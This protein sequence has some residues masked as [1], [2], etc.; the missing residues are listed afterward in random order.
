M[1]SKT[2]HYWD[3][4][5][6]V[7]GKYA[8]LKFTNIFSS[9]SG[10][11]QFVSKWEFGNQSILGWLTVWLSDGYFKYF[12]LNFLNISY[13]D[14]SSGPGK[15]CEKKVKER[16]KKWR[17]KY[18]FSRWFGWEKTCQN[19]KNTKLFRRAIFSLALFFSYFREL[20]TRQKLKECWLFA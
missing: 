4:E 9:Y 13:Y 8:I 20:K 14:G 18:F 7:S 17:K 1:I 2:S 15:E 11:S 3:I 10:D 6:F 5:I 16:E 12:I 19:K